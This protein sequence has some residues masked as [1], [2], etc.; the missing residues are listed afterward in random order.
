V[1]CFHKA[2]Q[3]AWPLWMAEGGHDFHQVLMFRDPLQ[4]A[5]AAYY[6]KH[7]GAGV[8][9]LKVA[10]TWFNEYLDSGLWF[11]VWGFVSSEA[12]AEQVLD[13]LLLGASIGSLASPRMRAAVTNVTVLSFNHY[14]ASLCLLGHE[15]AIHPEC[16]ELPS[17]NVKPHPLSTE[18]PQQAVT[19]FNQRAL[20]LGLERIFQKAQLV[21]GLQYQA[22]SELYSKQKTELNP[23]L[24]V[25][26]ASQTCLN[27]GAFAAFDQHR[28]I[29]S[30]VPKS[31]EHANAFATCF[32]QLEICSESEK[33]I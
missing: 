6:Q 7:V 15:L 20:D 12:D 9:S 19:L 10:Q 17:Q 18:W 2:Y 3:T 1:L 26:D 31:V 22:A 11:K 16:L 21:F 14:K 23:Q 8:P 33:V 30:L 13:E 25:R 27:L 28:L 5:V 29:Q 24:Q 32:Q 4:Q